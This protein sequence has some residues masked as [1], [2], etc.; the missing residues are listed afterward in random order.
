MSR[1]SALLFQPQLLSEENGS[2]LLAEL[3]SQ[4]SL[5]KSCVACLDEGGSYRPEEL[6]VA[7]EYLMK[8]RR[9]RVAVQDGVKIAISKEGILSVASSVS[10]EGKNSAVI[11]YAEYLLERHVSELSKAILSDQFFSGPEGKRF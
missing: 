5:L 2:Q 11:E 7:Q 8:H 3:K 4:Y 9:D 10:D 6:L 1:K